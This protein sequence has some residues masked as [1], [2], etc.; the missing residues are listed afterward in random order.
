MNESISPIT[1]DAIVAYLLGRNKESK[2]NVVATLGY[3][4]SWEKAPL[5][6][7]IDGFAGNLLSHKFNQG[8]ECLCRIS[9]ERR[10][11]V[12]IFHSTL[13]VYMETLCQLGF[14]FRVKFNR[15]L[16]A[17]VSYDNMVYAP[18]ETYMGKALVKILGDFN[19][20]YCFH[21]LKIAEFLLDNKSV[22]AE[23]FF[24]NTITPKLQR[25]LNRFMK[26]N[27]IT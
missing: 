9:L 27:G 6:M 14:Q 17:E 21:P 18:S 10:G 7:L 16:K 20:L 11:H 15:L 8:N 26:K 1:I 23:N 24:E 13:G 4:I 25:A 12:Y 19:D 22:L 5:E 2:Y 3:P